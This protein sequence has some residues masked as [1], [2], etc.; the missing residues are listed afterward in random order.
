MRLA[1]SLDF[2]RYSFRVREED[3]VTEYTVDT[4]LWSYNGSKVQFANTN[5]DIPYS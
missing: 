4:D 3:I 1:D 5:I 2:L